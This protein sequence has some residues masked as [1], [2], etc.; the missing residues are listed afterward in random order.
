M[1]VFMPP[2]HPHEEALDFWHDSELVNVCMFVP[3]SGITLV[4]LEC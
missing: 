4:G 2:L 1:N 3:N